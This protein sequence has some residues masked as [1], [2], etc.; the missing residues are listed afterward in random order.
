[1]S[2]DHERDAEVRAWLARAENDLRAAE[3][4]RPA[5]PP[6]AGDSLF[7][8]QQTIEKCLKAFLTRHERRFRKTHDLVELGRNCL[9]VDRR[10]KKSSK[11]RPRSRST[12]GDIA[13]QATLKN[14]R[15]RKLTRP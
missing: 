5:T 2:A 6:L 10:S 12:D 15:Q 7:H 3:H 1:M 9:D 8:A 4:D 11:G 13:I 14:R